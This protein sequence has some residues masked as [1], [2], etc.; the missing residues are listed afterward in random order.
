[1]T[2]PTTPTAALLLTT[3]EAE[4]SHWN[5]IAT[6]PDDQNRFLR[7]AARARRDQLDWAV[8]Q[9]KVALPAIEAEA[10][11]RAVE[12]STRIDAVLE[13]VA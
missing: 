7:E 13:S 3:F 6:D 12:E 9:L 2:T 4:A 1:M 11:E 10:V 8:A 5:A